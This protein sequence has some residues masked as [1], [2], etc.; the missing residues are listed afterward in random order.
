MRSRAFGALLLCAA[1]VVALVSPRAGRAQ[2]KAGRGAD[3]TEKEASLPL[4]AS[5]A[6]RLTGAAEIGVR[7][8]S[9]P[10]TAQQ[11]GKFE[12]Y[13]DRPT[14]LLLQQL[15]LAYTPPDSFR[16]YRLTA[17]DV[18]LLDQRLSLRAKQPGLFDFQ[19]LWDRLPHLFSSDA[20]SLFTESSRGVYALPSPRPDTAAFNRAEF[21]G[22]IRTVWEPVKLALGLTP[23]S[24]WDFKAEY[25]RIG[26]RGERPM[27]QA[28]G[29]PG[30]NASEI[31]EPIDQTMHDLKLS[32]S[33]ARSSFQVA[34]TYDVSLFR[35]SIGS[36]SSDNPLQTTD[37]PTAGAARGRT[38]LAPDNVAHTVVVTGGVELPARTRVTGNA[39]V[40][41]WRQDAAFIPSTSN[42]AI[43][44]P[45][46]AQVPT[47]L[48]GSAR[49]ANLAASV[50]T[51]PLPSLTFSG[52]FR[53][54]AYRDAAETSAIPII[55]VNDRSVDPADTARRDPF[56]RR[57]ADLS[58]SW[59]LIEPLA[60]SVGYAWEQM[61]RDPLER[62]VLRTNERTPRVTLDF[63]GFEWFGLRASYS[64]GWRRGT[65]YDAGDENPDSRRFDEADRD[66]ERTN[67]MASITP[68]ERVTLTGTWQVG[69]DLYPESR[70]GVQSDRSSAV[71]ADVSFSLSNWLTGGFGVMRETFDD[72]MRARY[73]AGTQLGNPTY[74]WI[75][76][77]TDVSTTT[78][79]DLTA[80][81]IPGRLEAGA[82]YELSRS[83]YAMATSNPITPTGGTAAQD[84]S[85]TAVDLPEVSQ[86]LQPMGTYVR[87]RFR[88]EWAFTLRYYGELYTQRDYKTLGV[89]PA[90]ATSATALF[91]FLGNNFQNY[92][93]RY[94]TFSFT[95]RPQ[96]IRV[97][98]TTL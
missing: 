81:V 19:L 22:P 11:R 65:G 32:Q 56:T 4:P 46:L 91:L 68:V 5:E 45:R 3:T 69:H 89:N 52:R 35:N 98:R 14:G 64:K 47:S 96:A 40:S 71:G 58:G 25:T 72:L 20:R 6:G 86:T 76:D 66:R 33:Y 54:Y 48:G 88:P 18:G 63:T 59:R 29:G 7:S 9:Q 73:R 13:R 44:D 2:E 92:D 95:Y 51:R 75:G 12:E 1:G 16:S 49:T 27:G 38:A 67:L 84:R 90:T 17:S 23:S 87:Y 43:V 55:I 10:L 80:I 37:T 21:V 8:F 30:A 93:A 26:K 62:Q 85:A 31:L 15:L 24:A 41:W 61:E 78:S 94:F 77:N 42:S 60:L 28:F 36:V 83:R 39:A 34:A 70:Y 79:A 50:T 57:N 74:D 82:S 97:G 53:S